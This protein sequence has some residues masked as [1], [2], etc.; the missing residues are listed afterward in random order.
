M[1]ISSGSDK[2]T[3]QEVAF[4][5]MVDMLIEGCIS[6]S[7]YVPSK[8]MIV[9]ANIDDAVTFLESN[10]DWHTSALNGAK[11]II[12]VFG[13]S[14]LKKYNFHHGDK[15]FNEIRAIGKY[16]S[17]LS[18]LDK[19]NPAD[20]YFIKKWNP[21]KDCIA[22]YNEYVS[23]SGDV[24]GVSLKKGEKEALHGAIA[25]N[26]VSTEFGKGKHSVKY[27]DKS[28]AFIKDTVKSLKS[29]KQHPMKSKI[30]VHSANKDFEQSLKMMEIK[31]AN[32]FKSVPPSIE[33]LKNS[34][35]DLERMLK[36]AIMHAMSISPKSCPH[37]K[38]EGAKLSKVP[39]PFEIEI[40]RIRIKI[41]GNTDTVTDFKFNGKQMK[42][43]LRSKGS[44]PQFTIIKTAE[45]PKDIFKI[46]EMK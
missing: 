10:A 4:L 21:P 37:Y 39:E 12:S 43:Q 25:L 2:T 29:L 22:K 40:I 20:I 15:I 8:R 28:D 31:S 33:F 13:A 23:M 46:S 26:V 6:L 35:K 38:L 18:N 5:I 14:R 3:L 32:Y 19:W 24:I 27:K 34:G 42:L 45:N 11:K 44:L 30:F 1:A 17:G 7:D 9:K 41:N 36:F 16:L